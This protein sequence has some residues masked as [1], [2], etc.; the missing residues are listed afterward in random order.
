MYIAPNTTVYILN[1]IPLD[2]D[3]VNTLYFSSTNAQIDY[4][5]NHY[6][7]AVEKYSYLRQQQTLRTAIPADRLY[8]CNYLMFQNTSYGSK[9]FYAFITDVKYVNNECTEITFEIDVMQTWFF[10]CVVL[11]SFVEREHTL[12]DVIGENLVPENLEIGD[13]MCRNYS[14]TGLLGNQRIVLACT[15]DKNFNNAAGGTYGGLY[16]GLTFNVFDTPALANAFIDRATTENKSDG[17]VA[18]FQIPQNMVTAKGGNPPNFQVVKPANTSDIDGYVP[19]NNKLFTY[20]YN[21]LYVTNL[22]GNAAEFHYEYFSEGVCE[23]YITGDMSCNP[24]VILYPRKYKG[25]DNNYNEKMILDGFPQC[26]FTTD[27]FKAWLA[28]NASSLG[29]SMLGSAMTSAGGLASM[30]FGNLGG[31]GQVASGAIGI[32][33]TLAKV[34]DHSSL[35]RQAHGASGSSALSAVG[36]KE[37]AFIPMTIR[38]EFAGIVDDYFNMFGYACH[39]VKTPNRSSRP[40]WNYVKTLNVNLTGTVPGDALTKLRSIY[41]TGITFWKNP[42]EVGDYNLDNRP[43]A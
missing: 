24:Q 7:F 18:C 15:F 29:V 41:D 38:H 21:F 31:L 2:R 27:T 36:L 39:Q 14:T 22:E 4:F 19:R 33:G 8:D 11:R 9:Y 23:F 43:G 30:A 13:Y 42:N 20:P 1:N 40:H 12:T 32:A 28:Q 25:I 35:P 6:K 17:I 34:Q 10:E 16:S 3:Y 37:F 26:P 5:S